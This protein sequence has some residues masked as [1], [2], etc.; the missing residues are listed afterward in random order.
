M[1]RGNGSLKN[2][3]NQELLSLY[4]E[5]DR[6]QIESA[7]MEADENIAHGVSAHAV[8]G[9]RKLT[10]K[11]GRIRAE[12]ERRALQGKLI[13]FAG[14]VLADDFRQKEEAQR[15]E[16]SLS[17][18]PVEGQTRVEMPN[19]PVAQPRR[20]L[21]EVAKRRALV[22][23]N[24]DLEAREMCQ[25]FDHEYVPLPLKWRGAGFRSW[26]EAYQGPEIRSRI[27]VLISKDRRSR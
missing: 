9:D 17:C 7:H 16:T 21:P 8:M 6:Q 10:I 27:H 26:A 25:L 12:F 2:L 20:V 4:K 14:Q 24:P 23:G 18:E 19:E 11:L 15:R 3:T 5:T 1:S 22:R 13:E